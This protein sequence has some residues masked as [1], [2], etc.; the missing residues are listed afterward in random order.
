MKRLCPLA[1]LLL[2]ANS[3][4]AEPGRVALRSGS[5]DPSA[6]PSDPAGPDPRIRLV[7][8]AGPPT[9]AQLEALAGAVD[10]IYTYLPEHTFLVRATEQSNLLDDAAAVGAAWTGP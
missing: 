10:R 6:A 4:G 8:F 2:L 1:L 5:I 9:A 3:L 7:K